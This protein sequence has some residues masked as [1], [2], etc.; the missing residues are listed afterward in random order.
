MPVSLDRLRSLRVADVMT[1][2]VV[3]LTTSQ[4]LD[5]A[6]EAFVAEDVSG[7]TVVDEVGRCV[8][9]LSALDFVRHHATPG[10]NSQAAG[11]SPAVS[12][13]APSDPWSIGQAWDDRVATHMSPAVQ[14]IQVDAPLAEAARIMAIAHVHR[15]PVLD[16]FA[17]PAGMIT[18]LDVVSALVHAVD[19]ANHATRHDERRRWAFEITQEHAALQR[20]IKEIRDVLAGRLQTDSPAA[21]IARLC[22]EARQHFDR[23]EAGG[24]FAEALARAPGLRE[25]ADKLQGEHEVLSARLKELAQAARDK[26]PIESLRQRFEA[27][28]RQWLRH[29]ADE[30][31]L[32]LT[33]YNQDV[34]EAD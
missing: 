28:S 26:L 6:A 23:E 7:A 9:V 22:R 21:A 27:L 1:R 2:R 12:R 25:Q 18:A 33:A 19:E 34:P 14:S 5:E 8:G 32:L 4:T 3:S 11:M 31:R 10:R 15:L 13:A 16:D 30:N 17:R 20:R 24:Y 29:E